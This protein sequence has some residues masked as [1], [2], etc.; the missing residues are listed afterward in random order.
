MANCDYFRLAWEVI[1]GSGI[2]RVHFV[3]EMGPLFGITWNL[4][5]G[6]SSGLILLCFSLASI[7]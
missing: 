3:R 1:G 7:T 5:R 6:S 2:Q 4:E